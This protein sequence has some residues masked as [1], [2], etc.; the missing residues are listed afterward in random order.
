MRFALVDAQM[1]EAAPG[2]KGVCPGCEAPVAAYCGK[3]RLWHWK[4][5]SKD[6]CDRWWE[7]ETE[8]HRR[9]KDRFPREWQEARHRDAQKGEIHIADVLTVHGAVIEFQHSRIDSQERTARERFYPNLIWI[10]D[11]ARSKRDYPRFLK[12]VNNYFRSTPKQGCFLV[13]FP[14]ECFPAEWIN[15]PVPVIFDFRGVGDLDPQEPMRQ[16][17]WCLL[18]RRTGYRDMVVGMS[19][20][21]LVKV[22]SDR[23][24]LFP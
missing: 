24:Q 23:A 15:S 10:V 9:W 8:W 5:L 3:Q 1:V 22:L 18:P 12:G 13:D 17:L 20:D 11:G 14:G 6:F 21:E 4:H 16:V 19:A 7:T 2:L